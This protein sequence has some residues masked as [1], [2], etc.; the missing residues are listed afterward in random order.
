MV[1]RIPPDRYEYRVCA[2]NKAGAVCSEWARITTSEGTPDHVE[3]PQI[4][5]VRGSQV[6]LLECLSGQE[7]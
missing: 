4:V 2:E 3:A 7:R 6:G 5:H 1:H